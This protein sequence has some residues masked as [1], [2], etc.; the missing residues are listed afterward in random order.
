MLKSQP[1]TGWQLEQLFRYGT[2]AALSDAQLLEQFV[3]GDEDSA[4][5][6]FEVIVERHGAMVLRVCRLVVRD[7]H[8]A[9][10]AFQATFLVL[11]RRARAIRSPELL[12]NWLHG[13]ALRTAQ[14]VRSVRG[15]QRVLDRV[16]ASQL[17]VT[18]AQVTGHGAS[19]DL[20]QALHEEIN[21][22]P[23]P[24]RAAVVVC[25]LEG[26]SQAQAARQ[27]NLT[28]TTIRGR[29]VR[30]RTL[31]KRRLGGRGMSPFGGL[32]TPGV[33]AGA[34]PQRVPVAIA[35]TT[36]R[37][38]L[39]FAKRGVA[40]PCIS[41][42]SAQ[43]IAL[44]VLS[45]MQ[46][47]HLK[48]IVAMVMVLDVMVRGAAMI[49]Q[50][51]A[52]AQEPGGSPGILDISLPPSASPEASY[53]AAFPNPSLGQQSEQKSSPR[54]KSGNI[55]PDLVKLVHG[56]I[57]RTVPVSKDCMVL[58]YLPEWNFGNVDNIGIG[59][60]DGGVRTL[61]NW[62][63]IPPAEVASPERKFLLALFSRKTISHPPASK[64]YAFDILEEW[65]ERTS[66]R[67]QPK[68]DTE[69]AATFE[70]EPD[71]G[72][73][74]FDV[75]PLLRARAKAGRKGH[76]VLLRFLKEDVV[77]TGEEI[78]SDYKMVSREGADEWANRHPLLLVVKASQE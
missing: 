33:I 53:P 74:L 47:S 19:E 43:S 46:F 64:I 18:V 56:Q 1:R 13:V 78:F 66:W 44:G 39:L 7:L 10:D 55:D 14:K 29:L 67:A 38:A 32:I 50:P 73:K 62:P 28:E 76:G 37:A 71:E 36:V 21:R 72:W 68:Y 70:F 59:N 45:A 42:T 69:P 60:N 17:S 58:A 40:I 77:G 48:S 61:L 22:L 51:V 12:A 3:T 11:A 31:L 57:I 5:I 20:T 24:Y 30:A 49:A 26:A 52:R 8:A 34:F 9:E 54:A 23:R 41:S 75:T 15:R 16:V 27:L 35:Q 65:P 25:Y 4:E 2:V 63:D 6:A